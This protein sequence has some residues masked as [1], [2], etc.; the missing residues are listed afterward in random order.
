MRKGPW[1]MW[2]VSALSGWSTP[3]RTVRNCS[4]RRLG[5]IWADLVPQRAR[6]RRRSDLRQDPP[7]PLI[8]ATFC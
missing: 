6:R 7:R 2:R 8:F 3:R 4:Q 1:G 5:S